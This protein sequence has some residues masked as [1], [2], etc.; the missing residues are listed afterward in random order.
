MPENLVLREGNLLCYKIRTNVLSKDAD[1]L[2]NEGLCLIGKIFDEQKIKTN[3]LIDITEAGIFSLRA[4]KDWIDFLQN[5]NIHRTAIF[6]GSIVVKMIAHLVM[7]LAGRTNV[8]YFVNKEDAV[9]WLEDW[10]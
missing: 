8:R 9:L 6:G 10:R 3:V 1:R 2:K 5:E 7:M 4:Q